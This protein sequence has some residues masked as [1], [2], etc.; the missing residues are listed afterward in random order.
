MYETDETVDFNHGNLMF[1]RYQKLSD[2]NSAN[3][4]INQ[5]I[6]QSIIY[7]ATVVK[8]TTDKQYNASRT[9]RLKSTSSCPEKK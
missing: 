5:S 2:T 7:C 6:N 8:W 9:A 4:V 1:W 3:A